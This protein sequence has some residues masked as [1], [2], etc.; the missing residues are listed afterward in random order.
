MFV[1][2]KF[3]IGSQVETLKN[4]VMSKKKLQRKWMVVGRHY[5]ALV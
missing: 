3:H 1:S 5:I 4:I 2:I